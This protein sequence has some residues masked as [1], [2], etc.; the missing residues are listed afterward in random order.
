MK[1]KKSKRR[2]KDPCF[3]P[4]YQH[5]WNKDTKEKLNEHLTR[6]WCDRCGGF[7]DVTRIKT[8]HVETKFEGDHRAAQQFRKKGGGYGTKTLK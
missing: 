7:K 1:Y 5:D 8:S 4:T 3:K 2:I 6:Y